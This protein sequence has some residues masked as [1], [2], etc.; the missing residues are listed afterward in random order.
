M[1]KV[2]ISEIALESGRKP[3][4]VL[5]ACEALGIAAKAPSSA[6]S[7]EEA[8]KLAEFLIS[9][10]TIE[11]PKPAP[12]KPKKEEVAKEEVKKPE[13]K[14][15]E[16]KLD[17]PKKVE[18]KPAV[19]V[20]TP[21][22]MA[23]KKGGITLVKRA[24]DSREPQKEERKR[25]FVAS[26]EPTGV[27][28]RQKIAADLSVVEKKKKKEKKPLTQTSKKDGSQ[29]IE[30][31][32]DRELDSKDAYEDDLIYIPDLSVGISTFLEEQARNQRAAKKE[33]EKAKTISS[34]TNR[35]LNEGISRGKKKKFKFKPQADQTK[36]AVTAI[37]IAEDVR[38]YEFAELIN[39]PIAKVITKLFELGMMVTKNDFLGKDAIEI[40]SVEFGIEVRTKDHS[41]EMDYVA[42]YDAEH[43]DATKKQT[44][45]PIVTIMGHVDH[46]KT[47]LLDY[48]RNARV[49]SGEAGGITQHIGAYTVTKSGKAV[50]FID[51]PGHEVFTEMRARGANAT[52]IVIIVVAADD[53]VMMQTKE[54]ISHA[55]AAKTPII[56]AINKIDKPAANLDKVKAELAEADLTP[57]DWGGDIETVGVSAKT[58]EGIETLLETILLQAE[59]MDLT[60]EVGV[61]AKAVVIEGAL[62]KGRGPVATVIVQNGTL[63]VGDSVVAGN[64]S[65]RVRAIIDD[66]GNQIKALN[67]SEAGEIVGLDTVPASG[68]V[69][70]AM[71]DI[72]SAK[73]VAQK[74]AEYERQRA[75]SRSTKAT[76][77][78]LQDLIAEG[79]LKRLPIILKADVQGT[80][81]AIAQNLSKLRNDEVKVDIVHSAV[82]AI[83]ESDVALAS[84]SEHAVIMGFNVKPSQMIKEKA[85]LLG[86]RIASYD[87]IY[88]LIE[89][90]RGIL[91][92]M[93]SPVKEER[94]A[95]KAEVRQI[96]DIPKLGKIAGS[97]VTDGEVVK[98]SIARVMRGEDEV[99]KGKID[100]LKRFKDDVK[101]VKKGFEC[102]IGISGFDGIQAGDIIEIYKAVEVKAEFE[103]Q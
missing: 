7:L 33:F 93:L 87:V 28:G 34:A 8:E 3:K 88:N 62:E 54:A 79:R 63:R 48:I 102:G 49:A 53:G 92:G 13:P 12:K 22:E 32:A 1:S 17:Q 98:G 20:E 29:R 44:R 61:D 52:D 67:P 68:D 25:D 86:V 72:E 26:S 84:A 64:S 24:R 18:E 94:I 39:Q 89:A 91:G 30:L 51:T 42:E 58:G 96:F 47:S 60:A 15:E 11:P 81:E 65:G 74:R 90:V 36:E 77:D 6:V 40:L 82:G 16:K 80:L 70:I 14:K 10:A 5:D 99:Y 50:T 41:E 21:L 19:V 95:G 71:R 78:D 73:A 9:G 59:I 66:R 103:I 55:K 2:R 97:M 23:K 35:I 101:E 4:E 43:A 31:L 85:K 57:I 37:E 100:T 38:V 56:V 76:L 45:P 83:S 69:M 27:Y 46:G 75:L